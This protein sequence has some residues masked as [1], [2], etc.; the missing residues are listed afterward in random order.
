MIFW[1]VLISVYSSKQEDSGGIRSVA[2]AV[3]AVNNSEPESNLS[4]V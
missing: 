3:T 2:A 4:D 1:K